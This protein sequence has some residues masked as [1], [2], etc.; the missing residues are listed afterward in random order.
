MLDLKPKSLFASAL[1][2]I[3]TIMTGISAAVPFTIMTSDA[4]NLQAQDR[5][6]LPHRSPLLLPAF[7]NAAQ[8]GSARVPWV[9]NRLGVQ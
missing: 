6:V 3:L 4:L 5:R 1:T 7:A 8:A 9:Q 2:V